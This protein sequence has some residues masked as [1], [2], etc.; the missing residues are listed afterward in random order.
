MVF[1]RDLLSFWCLSALCFSRYRSSLKSNTGTRSHL[2]VMAQMPSTVPV[3][4]S[5][6]TEVRQE[7]RLKVEPL[8][9]TFTELQKLLETTGQENKPPGTKIKANPHLFDQC[10]GQNFRWAKIFHKLG[11]PPLTPNTLLGFSLPFWGFGFSEAMQC[12]PVIHTVRSE[13]KWD[14]EKK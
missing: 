10:W 6:K 11:R 3:P 2:P 7:S 14:R 1:K 13:E 12:V 4:S 9:Q 8:Y 5:H